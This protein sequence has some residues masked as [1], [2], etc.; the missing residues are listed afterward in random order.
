MFVSLEDVFGSVE[1][2]I[3]NHVIYKRYSSGPHTFSSNA[4]RSNSLVT[5][6]RLFEEPRVGS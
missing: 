1:H 6:R 5:R 3:F 4:W 2:V